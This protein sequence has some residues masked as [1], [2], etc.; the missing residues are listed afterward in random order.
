MQ[1]T[2]MQDMNLH[3]MLSQDQKLLNH[4]VRHENIKRLSVAMLS[5]IRKKHTS[6]VEDQ[7]LINSYTRL[8][9]QKGNAWHLTLINV[10]LNS[11]CTR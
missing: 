5:F 7:I 1:D 2:R 11:H 6:A 3:D 4:L 9:Y 10:R 8:L